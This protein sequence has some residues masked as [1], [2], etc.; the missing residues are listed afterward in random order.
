MPLTDRN[1]LFEARRPSLGRRIAWVLFIV[2]LVL[3]LLVSGV[4]VAAFQFER[5]TW[6]PI[7]EKIAERVTGRRLLLEGEVDARIGRVITLQAE[8]VRLANADWGSTEDLLIVNGAF[9]SIDLRRLWDGVVLIDQV[10][11]TSARVTFEQ[12]EQGRIN[13]Q[14]G[15]TSSS[16]TSGGQR[17]AAV[18]LLLTHAALNDIHIAVT[19]PA[20]TRTL[21]IHLD[22]VIQEAGGDDELNAQ[23]VG[24]I[25]DQ[26]IAINAR[27]AP[28]T[29]LLAARAVGFEVDADLSVL[30]IAGSGHLDDLLRPREPTAEL[31]I[32]AP[33]VAAVSEMLALPAIATGGIDVKASIVPLDDHHQIKVTGFVGAFNVDAKARLQ[34]LDS[35]DGAALELAADGPDLA[36]AAS[37]AGLHGVPEQPFALKSRVELSG[38]RLQISDT[39][40][41]VGDNHLTVTG[42][43]TDFPKLEGTTL[44]LDLQGRNYLEFAELAGLQGGG[45]L[46][47]APFMVRADLQYDARDKQTFTARTTLGDISG[48]FRGELT[49]YPAFVGSNLDFLINGPDSGVILRALGRPARIEDSYILQ[50]NV[51]R[52][53]G[54]VQIERTTLSLG[55]NQLDVSGTVGDDPLRE[56]TRVSARYRGPDL[57]RIAAIAGFDGFMPRGDAEISVTAAGAEQGIKLETLNA[58]LGRSNLTGSGLVSL[59][60]DLGGSRIEFTLKGVDIA[61][62]VPAELLAYVDAGQGFDVSATLSTKPQ[63]LVIDALDAKLGEVSLAATGRVDLQQPLEDIAVTVDLAGPDLAELIPPDMVPY[64]FPPAPFTV[65]GDVALEPSGLKLSGVAAGIGPDRMTVDGTIPLDTP[66]EGLRLDLTAKGPNLAKLLPTELD[67]I[68]VAETPYEVA[69]HIELAAGLLSVK[70]LDFSAAKGNIKGDVSILMSDPRAQGRFDLAGYGNNLSEFVPTLPQ[71]Q[72]APVAFDLEARGDW[73]SDRARIETGHLQL[74]SA[75]IDI[76]GDLD[77]PPVDGGSRLVIAARGDSLAELGQVPGFVLPAEPFHLDASLEGDKSSLTIPRLD[78]H[79]GDSDLRGALSVQL[80]DKPA[81]DVTLNSELLDLA[82]LMPKEAE[83]A[84]ELVDEAATEA[85]VEAAPTTDAAPQQSATGDGRVIPDVP[86]PA[87]LLQRLNLVT[88]IDIGELRLPRNTLRNIHVDT[89]LRDGDLNVENFTA[90]ATQG[91]IKARFRAIAS[92]DRLAANGSIEGV[93]LVLGKGDETKDGAQFPKQNFHLAFR[94]EGATSREVAANLNGYVQLTGGEGRMANNRALALYGN[95]FSEL[96]S[97]VNPFVKQEPYTTISCSAFFAD[98]VEGVVTINPGAVVQTDKLNMFADGQIDLKTERIRL[99]FNTTARRGIGVSVSDF[100][101]PFVGVGGTLASPGLG[102]NPE[103]TVVE[104][105]V[106]VA[107]GGMSIIAKGLFG[108]WFGTKNPCEKFEKEAEKYLVKNKAGKYREGEPKEP[109][110]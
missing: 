84:E 100:V 22:S 37:L 24:Q 14:M 39:Q 53:D 18:P 65:T 92:G 6:I 81:I 1:T 38:T 95:F 97:A 46:K 59:R 107:T 13:W 64:E 90:A 17:L 101:N 58:R 25:G 57:V 4:L 54:A 45:K 40:V 99:R 83:E 89:S 8:R 61:D 76:E 78:A 30:G 50:G 80:G 72:P 41:D 73:D 19:S 52:L 56:P 71:Y 70:Q 33:D 16:A 74:G 102:L 96:L 21:D 87:E 69:A 109:E 34:A 110:H 86:V 2:L 55:A 68:K 26:P 23:V 3:A 27:V 75:T 5:E 49:E 15:E 11:V 79:L 88:Q 42:L 82:K 98:I 43:M 106:A 29:Q 77:L 28:F 108:R 66:T 20:L 36:A 60:P 7:V 94:T 103:G 44:D 31:A 105:G 35:I 47:P 48:E 62:V 32:S 67:H 10:R 9:V 85:Q 91:E 12:D 51:Q 63:Q 93:D 104:G